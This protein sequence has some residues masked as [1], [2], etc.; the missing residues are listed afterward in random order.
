MH[1][2]TLQTSSFSDSLIQLNVTLLSEQFESSGTVVTL[3]WTAAN[4]NLYY[5]ITINPHVEVMTL[6]YNQMSRAWLNLTYNTFYNVNVV[7]SSSCGH[8]VMNH[9]LGLHY[10]E[11]N[12]QPFQVYIQL[13]WWA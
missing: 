3:G 12:K 9:F 11:Y 5:N 7:A 8:N 2:H 13:S 1:A 4:L 10:S 6:R